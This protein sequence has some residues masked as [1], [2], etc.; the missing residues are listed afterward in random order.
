MQLLL[1]LLPF[2]LLPRTRAGEIIGGHEA[3]PHSRPYMAYIEH[4]YAGGYSICGGI[5][6]HE[7]FVLTAAHCFN[8]TLEH[9][10]TNVLLGAHN[11]RIEEKTSQIIHMKQRFPHP[12]FIPELSIN[13]LMLLQLDKKAKL[14]KEVQILKLPKGEAKVMPGA[15]CQVAGWGML[16]PDIFANTLQEVE[17]TVVKDEECKSCYPIYNSATEI[18][19]GDPKTPKGSFLCDSGGPLVCDNVLHGVTTY[20]HEYR[21]K[22]GANPHVY[23]KVS[24]YLAWIKQVIKSTHL[25]EQ[26]KNPV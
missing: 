12:H 16:A 23:T 25:G 4:F 26:T 13:D 17:V 5:L 14:T 2:F 3:K 1:L 15:V 18:C 7:N 10:K 6:I 20:G 21:E 22:S 8:R 11:L 9:K 19:A 24:P